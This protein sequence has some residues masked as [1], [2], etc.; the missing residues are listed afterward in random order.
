MRT[1]SGSGVPARA[2][3]VRR[4]FELWRRKKAGS[5]DRIPESLWRAAVRLASAYGLSR[6]AH[7]L[8]VNYHALRKRVDSRKPVAV[9]HPGCPR[10]TFLE[11]TPPVQTGSGECVVELEDSVGS[12]MRIQLQGVAMP[13][14]ASFCRSLWMPRP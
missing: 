6:T 14:A 5:R 3:G 11:L 12:K 1:R 7:W 8:Q 2:E 4:R 10:P 9:N 13:D